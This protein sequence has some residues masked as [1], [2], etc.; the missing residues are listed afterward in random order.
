VEGKGRIRR[1]KL[2]VEIGGAVRCDVVGLRIRFGVI[3]QVDR[4]AISTYIIFYFLKFKNYHLSIIKMNEYKHRN[5]SDYGDSI[6]YQ[7]IICI[8]III[9]I[10]S[11]VN[12]SKQQ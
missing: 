7:L 5:L 9:I 10:S 6:L 4:E 3:E 11:V 8:S 2:V 1:N 12:I